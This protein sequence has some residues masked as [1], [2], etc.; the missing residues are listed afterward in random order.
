MEEPIVSD[1]VKYQKPWYNKMGKYRAKIRLTLQKY[2]IPTETKFLDC[3]SEEDL[4]CLLIDAYGCES[5]L[6]SIL[7]E[8]LKYKRK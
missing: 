6:K 2:K 4:L 5:V 8:E 7:S 3:K 1:Y